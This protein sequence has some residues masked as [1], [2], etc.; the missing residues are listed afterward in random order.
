MDF[1]TGVKMVANVGGQSTRSHT[2]A[3]NM[4]RNCH[5]SRS[6]KTWAIPEEIT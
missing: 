6:T 5:D 4:L 1:Q 2:P 3:T